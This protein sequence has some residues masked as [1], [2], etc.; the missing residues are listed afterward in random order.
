MFIHA[1]P[2]IKY[3]FSALGL[4]LLLGA[5]LWAQSI[6]SFI[7]EAGH[8]RGVV[9]ELKRTR[10]TNSGTVYNPVV[11]FYSAEGEL[12]EFTSSLGSNP[13]AYEEGE[14]VEVLYNAE[15]PQDAMIN[16]FGQLWFGITLLSVAGSV[17]LLVGLLFFWLDHRG[18]TP[19]LAPPL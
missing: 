3:L 18:T 15:A 10:S 11:Q 6:Q 2:L 4:L 17:F 9:V 5:G 13:P 1:I 8:T 16:S 7:A 19:R 14:E 12:V